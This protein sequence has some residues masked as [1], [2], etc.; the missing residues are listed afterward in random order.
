[1]TADGFRTFL[2]DL[3]GT[4]LDSIGLIMASY[5]HTALTHRGTAPE[6]R[7]WLAGLGTPLRQQL[8]VLTDDPAEIE[9]MAATYRD[10]NFENHDRMVR[11]YP[12]VVNAVRTLAARGALGLV[13]SKLHYGAVR[14]LTA[15]GLE[16]LFHVVIGADDITRPKPDP[17]PVLEAVRRLDADP[18]TTVFIGDSPHDM[19]AGRAAGVRTAAVLWG[20]FPRADLEPCRP[21]RWLSEPHELAT[22]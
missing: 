14:G 22:L 1:M 15:A 11:P 7:V 16:T 13:T 5:R 19:A 10:Y 3:D 17:E 21:D 20:P 8:R 2:F 9:A 6:D 18:S 12:G 4:I